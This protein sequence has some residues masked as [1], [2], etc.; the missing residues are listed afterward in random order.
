ML[1]GGYLAGDHGLTGV[2]RSGEQVDGLAV[3]AGSAHGLAV[4][5]QADQSVAGFV[6]RVGDVPGEPGAHGVVQGIA[7]QAGQESSQRGGV[8]CTGGQ[9]EWFAQ[10][11]VGIGGEAGDGGQGRCSAEDSDQSQRE[12]GAQAVAAAP[13]LAWIGYPA[14]DLG[15]GNELRRFRIRAGGVDV[16][17][18]A[19]QDT[20]Q[21]GWHAN[22]TPVR[23]QRL[24]QP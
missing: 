8:R 12:Q 18:V 20:D 24:R 22:A 21:G 5:G 3:G 16:L 15:Q 9:S 1:L 17:A 11:G 4:D 13:D 6:D 7:V 10:V 14:Q 19:L 2:Q 23:D